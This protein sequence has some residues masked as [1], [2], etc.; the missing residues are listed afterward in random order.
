MGSGVK[1]EYA[2]HHPKYGSA[3][4][5]VTNSGESPRP[6]AA[7]RAWSLGCQVLPDLSLPRLRPQCAFVLLFMYFSMKS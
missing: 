3:M 4:A 1:Q 6:V 7:N 2:S 5:R